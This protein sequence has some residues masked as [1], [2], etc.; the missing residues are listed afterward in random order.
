M[1]MPTMGFAVLVMLLAATAQAEVINGYLGD[2]RQY[3]M[4]QGALYEYD[5]RSYTFTPGLYFHTPSGQLLNSAPEAVQRPWHDGRGMV[6]SSVTKFEAPETGTYQVQVFSWDNQ[7]PGQP[8]S[9]NDS[10]IGDDPPEPVPPAP[11]SSCPSGS[12]FDPTVGGC[13]PD[14][15][16]NYCGLERQ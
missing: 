14:N 7:A 16:P 9:M 4:R 1:K 5:V 12:C 8:Y 15:V 10:L 3:V 13:V 6:Y 11:R 2:T